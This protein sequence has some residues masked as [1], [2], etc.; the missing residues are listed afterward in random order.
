MARKISWARLGPVS[1]PTGWPGSSSLMTSVMRRWVPCSRPLARLTTGTHGRTCGATCW[2]RG[3]HAV[4]RDAHD[5]HVG[6]GSP[7]PP[8]TRWPRSASGSSNSGQVV[9]VAVVAGDLVGQLRAPRPQHRGGVAAG[10]GGDRGPPRPGTDHGD[11]DRACA[12]RNPRPPAWA[13]GGD[14][15]TL[16][17]RWQRRPRRRDRAGQGVPRGQG[18]PGGRA[19]PRRAGRARPPHGRD[20]PAGGRPTAGRGRVRRRRGQVLGRAV[21]RPG[22]V[23]PRPGAQW[24]GGRRRGGR[25]RRRRRAGGRGPRRPAPRHP[26]RAGWPTSPA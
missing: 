6:V 8:A 2:R 14:P 16:R 21:G 1:T 23:V 25:G 9:A 12:H 5:E 22:G 19:R 15:G 18:P 24:R 17:R 4:G 10:E 3:P 13:P 11:A 7:P 26:P 20:R